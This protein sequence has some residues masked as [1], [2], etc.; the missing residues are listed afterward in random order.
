MVRSSDSLS[1]DLN[2]VSK[3]GSISINLYVK[4]KTE[5]LDVLNDLL[6]DFKKRNFKNIIT[7]DEQI[8]FDDQNKANK[9]FGSFDDNNI[10]AKKNYN[11]IIFDLNKNLLF[12]EMIFEIENNIQSQIIDK[13]IN[14]LKFEK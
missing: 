14:S 9:I 4:N 8:E 2:Y 5:D 11:V 7:K 3:D 10:N 12:L 13:V 6:D 1:N